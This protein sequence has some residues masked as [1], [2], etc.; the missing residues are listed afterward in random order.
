[1]SENETFYKAFRRNFSSLLRWQQLDE[2]WNVVRRNPGAGWVMS[3][4]PPQPIESQHP[5]LASH[6][7]WWLT[8]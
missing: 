1:M 2:F 3:L 5:L 7:H 8:L 6:Q 4:I